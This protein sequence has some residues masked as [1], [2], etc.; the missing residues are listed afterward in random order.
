MTLVYRYCI[1][2][3]FLSVTTKYEHCRKREQY[4]KNTIVLTYYLTSGFAGIGQNM[5]ISPIAETL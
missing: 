3:H 4:I 2:A 1:F 5:V